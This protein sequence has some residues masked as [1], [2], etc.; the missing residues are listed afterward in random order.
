MCSVVSQTV[1]GVPVYLQNH[2]YPDPMRSVDRRCSCSVQTSISTSKI[3]VY[4]VHFQLTDG[5]GLCSGKQSLT[6]NDNGRNF[7]WTCAD[8]TYYTITELMESDTNYIAI[9]LDNPEGQDDG[10]VWIGF[11]GKHIC[12]LKILNT[13]HVL[14]VIADR[15]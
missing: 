7:T 1:K 6:L 12:I 3:R 5:G 15:S 2:N 11:E 10:Y 4:F 14:C 8:N 9:T 13:N